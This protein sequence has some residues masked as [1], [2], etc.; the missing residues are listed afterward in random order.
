[1]SP[2]LEEDRNAAIVNSIQNQNLLFQLI[3]TIYVCQNLI[4]RGVPPSA[5]L[6]CI[7]GATIGSKVK[8]G[9]L[10]GFVVPT[11]FQERVGWGN[12]LFTFMA[13]KLSRWKGVLSIEPWNVLPGDDGDFDDNDDVDGGDCDGGGDVDDGCDVDDDVKVWWHAGRSEKGRIILRVSTPPTR[14]H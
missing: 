10:R 7:F 3:L 5:W 9:L 13:S 4:M 1:M 12:W 11:H 6:Q 8:F 2:K 14:W